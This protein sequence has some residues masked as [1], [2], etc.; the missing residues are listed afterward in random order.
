MKQIIYLYSIFL[1]LLISGCDNA[2]KTVQ[3]TPQEQAELQKYINRVKA[4]LV[5]VKGGTFWMGDFCKKMRNGGPYCSPEKDTRPLHE[6]ELTGFSISK[7]KVTHEDYRFYLKI[8]GLPEQHFKKKSYDDVFFEM[9]HFK[10]SPAIVTW[11]E[12]NDYCIWLKNET[13]LPFS[14]PTEA[15]WEYA[16]RSRGQYIL[17]ATDDGV[18]REDEKSG[19]GENYATDED[20]RAVEDATGIDSTSVHFPVDK[21]P[22]TPLG[23]YGMTDNGWEW[24]KDWYDPDYYRNSAKKDPQGPENPVVK[25][26]D[27]GQYLKVLRGINHPESGTPEGTTFSR[28]S[29]IIDND[30][31]VSTTVRCV[32]NSSEPIK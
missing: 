8:A 20:R 32:M 6:V 5:Y 7:F 10:N 16:A 2:T 23:L 22:P 29:N 14:L 15:Q 3:H 26:E 24:M 18:W 1:I 17:V 11:T 19:Q 9:T 27:T 13:G 25:D 30:F 12:A 4:D 21:Y 31:P 28:A